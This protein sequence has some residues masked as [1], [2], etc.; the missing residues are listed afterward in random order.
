MQRLF[1]ILRASALPVD[2]ADRRRP[3]ATTGR[4]L[5]SSTP[6]A[7]DCAYLKQA[8]PGI[9]RRIRNCVAGFAALDNRRFARF[10]GTVAGACGPHP[11]DCRISSRGHMA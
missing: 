1:Q 4:R 8:P 5:S 10:D 9:V 2:P 6:A 3:V 11:T 7:R